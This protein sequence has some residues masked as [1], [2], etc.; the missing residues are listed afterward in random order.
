MRSVLITGA[1]GLV[2]SHA[3]E[4]FVSKGW[5]VRALVRVSSERSFL[6][7]LGC[8]MRTGDIEDPESLAGAAEGCEIVVHSAARLGSRM[9]WDESRVANEDGTRNVVRES[10]RAGVSRFVHVSTVSVYGHPPDHASHPIGEESPVDLAVPSEFRYERS[11]RLAELVVREVSPEHMSWT[12]VRPAIIVGE[13]DRLFTPRLVA[14]ARRMWIV[15]PDGG[16]HS[17]PV[18]YA[19][20]VALACLLAATRP[21][22]AGQTYNVADDGPLTLRRM[23]EMASPAGQTLRVISVP[24]GLFWRG[25]AAVRAVSRLIPGPGLP[26]N[27][28]NV[29]F[30]A[31]DNPFASERIRSLPGWNPTISAQEGWERSIEWYESQAS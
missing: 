9:S 30:I 15:L 19:G 26:V 4:L 20:S 29:W 11:K 25:F 14:A 10:V 17:L 22:A 6:E 16:R 18:V 2:G 21:E 23:L 12:I 27:E 31:N 1:S 28:R 5:H 24:G 8:E 7:G 3:A 13:R